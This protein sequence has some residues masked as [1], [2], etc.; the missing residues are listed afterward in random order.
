[1]DRGASWTTV[2]GSQRVRHDRATRLTNTASNLSVTVVG[3][4]QPRQNLASGVS[5]QW[6]KVSNCPRFFYCYKMF[7]G[8]S[9]SPMLP[10]RIN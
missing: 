5:V 1:M 2:H 3:I 8:D 10:L 7:S 4:V 9:L 6:H